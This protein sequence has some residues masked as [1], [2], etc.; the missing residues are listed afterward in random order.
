MK[1][2]PVLAAVVLVACTYGPTEDHLTVQNV[3]LKPDATLLAVVVKYERYRQATGLAAFPDGGVPR[4]LEQR[5]DLYVID[6]RIRMEVYRGEIPAPPN[7]RLAFSPWLVGWAGDH[8]Y[9]KITGCEGFSRLGVL[10]SSRRRVAVHLSPGWSN[11][12]G[13][14]RTRFGTHQYPSRAHALRFSWSRTLWGLHRH[15]D[16][17]PPHTSPALH[18]SASWGRA[19]LETLRVKT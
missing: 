14:G 5:A 18:R 8:V 4:M 9:F 6:L 3:A 1:Y 13:G 15:A 19:K 11:H 12:L 16:R 10:R 7:R 17:R 2:A